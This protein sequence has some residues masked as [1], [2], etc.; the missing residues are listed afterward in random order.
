MLLVGGCSKSGKPTDAAASTKPQVP[1]TV[2]GRTLVT[3]N[4]PAGTLVMLE[5]LFEHT[6][7]EPA[8]PAYMDQSGQMF[9]PEFLT[10]RVGQKV[11]F[12]SSEDVLHNVRVD[13]SAT[14]TPIFNVATPP[15]GMYPHTFNK[16][17]FYNVSCDI[18]TTMRA[19]IFVTTTPYT[20]FA[21][22]TGSFAF[23]DVVRGSYKLKGF[24]GEEP[25]EKTV[26]VAGART[27]L[28]LQ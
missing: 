21:D 10:A 5:P 18:H 12:R 3:G 24:V 16:P 17:G 9:I 6:F 27:E 4:A 11:E 13:H 1:A 14:K 22:D 20:K 7:P 19:T 25:L 8:G 26:Q 23:Q 2:A 15:W 28:S